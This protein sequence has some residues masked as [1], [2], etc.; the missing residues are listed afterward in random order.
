MLD[1]AERYLLCIAVFMA[2]MAVLRPTAFAITYSD[3]V[4]VILAGLV[5]I[6]K[7]A[8]LAPMLDA[9]I[10]WM[11][12]ILCLLGGL[13]VS[14]IVNGSPSDAIVACTQYFFAY[15]LLP[16]I[17]L[18]KD[19][20]T[21]ILLVKTYV[22]AV[23]FAASCGI[24][25]VATGFD[26]GGLFITGSGRLAALSGN[27][28]GLGSQIAFTMP[29]LLYLWFS[30]L[31]SGMIC[32]VIFAALVAALIM[33]SSN[34]GLMMTTLAIIL[35]LLFTGKFQWLLKGAVL[36]TLVIVLVSTV[37]R[38]YLPETFERRVLGAFESGSLHE[39]GTFD[40]RMALNLEATEWIEDSLILG[41]GADQYR[42]H[43]RYGTP[44]HNQYLILWVE[45]G[46]FAL[47]GWLLLL[48]TILFVGIKGYQVPN[49]A[50]AAAAVMSLAITFALVSNFNTHIY[51]RNII[52]GVL[53][54]MGLTFVA[55]AA[56]HQG[57]AHLHPNQVPM[58]QT[59][60]PLEA[61]RRRKPLPY[62]PNMHAEIRYN[63]RR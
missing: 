2:P 33:T 53:V 54:A 47:L 24:V 3:I 34:S 22:F 48:A 39:A 50:P 4:F 41:I 38:D 36:V 28:N 49:G 57:M 58:Q 21:T 51:R 6:G 63:K 11:I 27:P 15:A 9:S 32:L 25:F 31:L 59:S 45:G 61:D 17:L 44:V 1:R 19:Q 20:E 14:S 5:I 55:R 37:G 35:Y 16:F 26:G 23:F 42:V 29:L 10:L 56:R 62:H 12:S 52:V 46:T 7:R 18:E 60:A 13:F 8:S 40:D 30:R 43:S